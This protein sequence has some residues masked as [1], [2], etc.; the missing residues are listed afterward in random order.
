MK[1]AIAVDE[2]GKIVS[3]K[4]TEHSETP[5]FGA[6]IIAKGFDALV[7]QDI[8]TAQI[9]VKSGVTFTCNGINEALKAAAAAVAPATETAP[10]GEVAAE[11]VAATVYETLG[12]Q[13]MKVAIAVDE[14]G[15]I[16]SVKVTEHS[17]TPGFGADIIA[18]GFDALVGQDIATAQIDV[19]SGVTFT[20]NG[21]NDALKQAAAAT[22]VTLPELSE[23]VAIPEE[24][25]NVTAYQIQV[26]GMDSKH[27]MMLE[28]SVD[29]NGKITAAVCTDN[30][31][32]KGA[33]VLTDEALATLVGQDI[34]TAK[35]EIKSGATVTSQAVNDALILI[36]NKVPT[37]D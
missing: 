37:A 14:A 20:C 33:E 31:E 4:V 13:A 7:G 2:A 27:P 15:K 22:P 6:D 16:V 28:V 19:K 18:N 32:D 29:D 35:V 23:E 24:P 34:S 25:V 12:F 3:V 21:I 26:M 9:D 17:E 10:V 1:V 5:G 8:A 36:A 30:S 11:E